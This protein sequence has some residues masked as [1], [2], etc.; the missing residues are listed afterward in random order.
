MTRKPGKGEVKKSGNS[1]AEGQEEGQGERRGERS[2]E[3]HMG[4]LYKKSFS[5]D[6][7]GI[8]HHVDEH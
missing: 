4:S 3:R 5:L 2:S 6:W 8:A 1:R 7:P